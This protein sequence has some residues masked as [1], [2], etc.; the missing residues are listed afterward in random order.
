MA[1]WSGWLAAH[2]THPHCDWSSAQHAASGHRQH[3]PVHGDQRRRAPDGPEERRLRPHAG[4]GDLHPRGQQG[5]HQRVSGCESPGWRR[6]VGGV[7]LDLAC[8][9]Q[10]ERAAGRLPADQQAE[11]KEETQSGTG[12]YAG[13]SKKSKTQIRSGPVWSGPLQSCQICPFQ[14]SPVK[15]FSSLVRSGYIQLGPVQSCQ[16]QTNQIIPVRSCAVQSSRIKLDPVQSSNRS[17]FQS[18]PVVS[19]VVS[20][21]IVIHSWWTFSSFALWNIH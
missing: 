18:D 8:P 6:A 2:C 1:T 3:E 20:L 15:M 12:R 21:V 17:P 14:F 19:S 4:A 7:T 11:P 13:R 9:S 10:V 16:I 5:D